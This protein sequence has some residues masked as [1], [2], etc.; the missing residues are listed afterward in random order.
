MEYSDAACETDSN[1]WTRWIRSLVK[2]PSGNTKP[3]TM[4]RTDLGQRVQLW[5]RI[6]W[7]DWSRTKEFPS[8]THGITC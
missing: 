1:I 6:R 3:M 8:P 7:P 5:E 2:R 4:D